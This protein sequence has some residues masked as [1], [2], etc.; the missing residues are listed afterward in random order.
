MINNRFKE[1]MNIEVELKEAKKTLKEEEYKLRWG[2]Y[3]HPYDYI[4]SAKYTVTRYWRNKVEE[5]ENKLENSKNSFFVSFSPF[6]TLFIIA[7]P[8]DRAIL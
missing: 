2:G 7:E 3:V 6:P 1:Y 4:R 8:V 5:L